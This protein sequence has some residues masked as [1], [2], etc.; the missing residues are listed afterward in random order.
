MRV[1][2]IVVGALSTII[3]IVVQSIYY[4]FVLCGDLVYVI[5]FPQLTCVLYVTWCNTYGACAGYILGLFFRLTGGEPL[6]SLPPLI[7]Y[8]NFDED[9]QTQLFPFKTMAM[10][11]SLVTIILV[12][13]VTRVLFKR[14][15]LRPEQDVFNCFKEAIPME[16]KDLRSLQ[17][18]PEIRD[19]GT[20]PAQRTLG[21]LS[22]ETVT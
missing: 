22:R 16:D 18:D 21:K 14:N 20:Q 19:P 4:L 8:P 1:S 2:V 12:S 11:I 17:T 5:V 3:A 13:Y 15:I 10:L 9:T 7:K 6:V